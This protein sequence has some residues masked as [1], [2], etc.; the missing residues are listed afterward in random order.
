MEVPCKGICHK[1]IMPCKIQWVHQDQGP[2]IMALWLQDMYI[3]LGFSPEAAKL[4][5]REQ[6]LD[7]PERLRDLTNKNIDDICYIM[8]KPG[9]KNYDRTSDRRQKV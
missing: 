3:W 5:I 9:D 7:S 8:R 1:R 6:G 4:L 2:E